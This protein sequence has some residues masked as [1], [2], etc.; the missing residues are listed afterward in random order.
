MALGREQMC[1]TA[2]LFEEFQFLIGKEHPSYC[3]GQ[4]PDN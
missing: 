3:Q 1:S 4:S 2:H